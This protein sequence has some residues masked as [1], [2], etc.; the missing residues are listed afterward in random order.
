MS[1]NIIQPTASTTPP[2]TVGQ[3][4]VGPNK[5]EIG[6]TWFGRLTNEPVLIHGVYKALDPEQRT[7]AVVAYKLRG[8]LFNAPTWKFREAF[9]VEP[10]LRPRMR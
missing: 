4:Y 6:S 2:A 5:I 10:R 7:V 8:E 1:T 9:A 3:G